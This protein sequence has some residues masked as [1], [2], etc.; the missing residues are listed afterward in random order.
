MNKSKYMTIALAALLAL[1]MPTSCKRNQMQGNLKKQNG[2]PWQKDTLGDRLS[3]QSDS[4]SLYEAFKSHYSDPDA[5]VV[6]AASLN[7]N[8]KQLNVGLTWFGTYDAQDTSYNSNLT[9]TPFSILIFDKNNKIIAETK[10]DDESDYALKLKGKAQ[11]V[12]IGNKQY[13]YFHYWGY[14]PGNYGSSDCEDVFYLYDIAYRKPMIYKVNETQYGENKTSITGESRPKVAD[15]NDKLVLQWLTDR[16]NGVMTSQNAQK[17]EP[18]PQ[19]KGFKETLD[20]FT[21]GKRYGYISRKNLKNIKKAAFKSIDEQTYNGMAKLQTTTHIDGG[22]LFEAI[23]VEG[24]SL[25]GYEGTL[26]I[27]AH[28]KQQ[29]KYFV[30]WVDFTQYAP[31]REDLITSININ[32]DVLQIHHKGNTE[33]TLMPCT[34]R[35]NLKNGNVQCAEKQK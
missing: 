13:L 10:A 34:F 11:I 14:T 35:V 12:N 17:E 20:E 21:A 22:R 7:I 8:G 32:A 31:L 27:I 18:L 33:G 16:R 15:D 28:D 3:S 2:A 29:N 1:A 30:A 4:T 26:S 23:V 19:N 24:K 5:I 25:P 9:K 6:K